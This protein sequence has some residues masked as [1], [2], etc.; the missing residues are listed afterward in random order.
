M[1]SLLRLA[2][3]L[4]LAP[5]LAAQLTSLPNTGCRNGGSTPPPIWAA[6]GAAPTIGNLSFTLQYPCPAAA[7]TGF[8][9]FGSCHSTGPIPNWDLS[10]SSCFAIWPNPP[11]TCGMGFQSVLWIDAVDV[12]FGIV[13]YPLPIPAIPSL[14]ALMQ[15]NPL[16][17][18]V[19]CATVVPG[20]VV[21]VTCAEVSTGAQLIAQ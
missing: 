4:L 3:L 1:R 21:S 18:Q 8:V 6:G 20:P 2:A 12:D 7:G 13:N 16:C 15:A 9:I 10:A 11:A 17:L 19:V 14:P 5:P